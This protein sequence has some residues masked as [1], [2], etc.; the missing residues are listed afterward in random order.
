MK[1]SNSKKFGPFTFLAITIGVILA[2]TDDFIIEYLG[3][4][5]SMGILFIGILLIS[6]FTLTKMNKIKK[7]NS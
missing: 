4:R 5:P 2:I 3:N 1:N 6:L 7:S